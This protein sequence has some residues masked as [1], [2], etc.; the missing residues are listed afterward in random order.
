[1]HFILF[2]PCGWLA[3]ACCFQFA[4]NGVRPPDWLRRFFFVCFL[5]PHQNATR[6]PT[7]RSPSPRRWMRSRTG[8]SFQ[9]W[10]R[11]GRRSS[12][13]LELEA[14]KRALVWTLATPLESVLSQASRQVIHKAQALK[15]D[16]PLRNLQDLRLGAAF[17][18]SGLAVQPRGGTWISLALMASQ[19]D[20]AEA[21]ETL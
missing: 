3:A 2:M 15:M 7:P 20:R 16:R 17:P 8:R 18:V 12:Q 6:C 19:T 9:E 4:V 13:S 10:T 11:W 5:F 21:P 1:M 14:L